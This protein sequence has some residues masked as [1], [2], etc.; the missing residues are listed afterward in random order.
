VRA[1]LE[2]Y[3]RRADVVEG[4]EAAAADIDEFVVTAPM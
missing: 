4:L 2:A 3:S 1:L